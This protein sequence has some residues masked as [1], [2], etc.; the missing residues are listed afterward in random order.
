[1]GS[2]IDKINFV[3]SFN[4]PSVGIQMTQAGLG[5]AFTLEGFSLPDNIVSRPL[6]PLAKPSL[7][8]FW[9]KDQ[10]FSP[11]AQEFLNRVQQ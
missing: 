7:Q 4:V 1:M 11:L 10:T 6:E 2:S 9:K 5:L 3:G 8:L